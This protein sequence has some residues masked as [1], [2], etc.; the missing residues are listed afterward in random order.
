MFAPG[1]RA[2]LCGER[3][4]GPHRPP[5]LRRT[6]R[7]PNGEPVKMLKVTLKLA[8]NRDPDRA[9]TRQLFLKSPVAAPLARSAVSA[10]ICLQTIEGRDSLRPLL[11]TSRRER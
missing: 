6:A 1:A 8:F 2:H 3:G 11:P 10:T 7:S 9:V 4:G 5:P